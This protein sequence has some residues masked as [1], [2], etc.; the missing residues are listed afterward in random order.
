MKTLLI[1][2]H[3]KSSWDDP[4]TRDHDRPLNRRGRKA[5]PR[6]GA[7]LVE[8]GLAPGRIVSS[9]ARRAL[10][11]AEL[12]AD[13]VGHEGALE[14][15]AA[16]YEA[17]A[18]AIRRVI[19]STP[20]P[21]SRLLVVG[22]NPGLADLVFELTGAAERFPTAALAQVELPIDAWHEVQACRGRLVGLWR[23]REL[24]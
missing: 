22:H 1:M 13:A 4:G 18:G 9:T 3:A 6:M 10:E 2:R 20:E 12:V 21:C 24:P 8:Q 23:P 5:A 14:A 16:L 19:A 15:E 11:T 17:G 7:W